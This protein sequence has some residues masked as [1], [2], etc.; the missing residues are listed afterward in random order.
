MDILDVRASRLV[1]ADPGLSPARV[2]EVIRL[3]PGPRR[4][5]LQEGYHDAFLSKGQVVV[6]QTRD[7]IYSVATHHLELDVLEAFPRAPRRGEAVNLILLWNKGEAVYGQLFLE[8]EWT[9]SSYGISNT[10]AARLRW[11]AWDT[12]ELISTAEEAQS[13][14]DTGETLRHKTII[15][16][17]R[18][19]VEALAK[20]LNLTIGGPSPSKITQKQLSRHNT[21]KLWET[22]LG[23]AF[24][25]QLVG[26]EGEI[27]G[28]IAR[29]T[30]ELDRFE[31]P[32]TQG[33][34]S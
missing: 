21:G 18:A 22:P 8:A 33:E 34:T 4:Y 27:T 13:M 16:R 10:D 5:D 20:A 30:V 14:N 23:H 26:P 12:R 17:E 15:G 24:E 31:D 9:S 28:H 6:G 1:V 7:E 11:R 19:L 32:A 29:I 3:D 2:D 25:V